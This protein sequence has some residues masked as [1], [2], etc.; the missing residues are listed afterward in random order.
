MGLLTGIIELIVGS[1]C[2]PMWFSSLP[3]ETPDDAYKI[4]FRFI[5][6]KWLTLKNKFAYKILHKQQYRH[7]QQYNHRFHFGVTIRND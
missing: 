5:Y 6:P 2:A 3:C 1:I 7:I 4:F